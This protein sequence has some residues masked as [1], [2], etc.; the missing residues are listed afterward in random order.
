MFEAE[1]SYA[2]PDARHT[3]PIPNYQWD[4]GLG[5]ILNALLEVGLQIQFLHEFSMT[6]FKQLPFME[7]RDGWWCLPQEMP[8]LPLFFSLKATKTAG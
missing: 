8:S 5:E 1:T 4:H 7:A 3:E 6:V 2:E